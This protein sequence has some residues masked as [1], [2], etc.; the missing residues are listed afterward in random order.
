MRTGF[1]IAEHYDSDSVV[2]ALERN[3]VSDGAPL[4]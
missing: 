2:E 4:V 3:I 1:F